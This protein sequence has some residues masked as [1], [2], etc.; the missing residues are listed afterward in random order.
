MRDH[1]LKRAMRESSR[2]T[3]TKRDQTFSAQRGSVSRFGGFKSKVS[4]DDTRGLIR[5]YAAARHK[6]PPVTL[7]KMPW[8]ES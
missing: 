1:K 6:R 2:E 3:R 4:P 5:M 7:P 8:N